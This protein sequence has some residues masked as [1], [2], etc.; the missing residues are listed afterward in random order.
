MALAAGGAT[1]STEANSKA[2][3]PFPEADAGEEDEE[4]EE[5]EEDEEDEE[6]VER[7][8]KNCAT[9]MALLQ[10]NGIRAPID[11]IPRKVNQ[12]SNG[13]SPPPTKHCECL[14]FLKNPMLVAREGKGGKTHTL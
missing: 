6:E 2:S 4:E 10:C 13:A 8:S 7:T 5:E 12:Q 14:I 1:S 11:R 3:A 9:W